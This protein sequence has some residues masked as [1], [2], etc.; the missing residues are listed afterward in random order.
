MAV[1]PFKIITLEGLIASG[2]STIMRGLA[3]R[4]TEKSI[5]YIPEPVPAWQNILEMPLTETVYNP[6]LRDLYRNLQMN[7]QDHRKFELLKRVYED[8]ERWM[9]SFQVNCMFY[10]KI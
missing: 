3:T 7:N 2:K 9:L 5:K 1:R 8:P 10:V 6:A 4:L